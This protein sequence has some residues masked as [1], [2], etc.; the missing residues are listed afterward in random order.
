MAHNVKSTMGTGRK[1]RTLTRFA[2]FASLLALVACSSVLGIKDLHEGPAPGGAGNGSG[3]DNGNGGNLSGGGAN[4]MAGGSAGK[5]QS[6]GSTG[7]AGSGASGGGMTTGGT[8]AT[9]ATGGD[10]AIAGAGG[11]APVGSSVHGHVID[12]WGH[13][14]ANVPVEIGGTLVTTDELGAFVI[15][16][17]PAEYDASLFVEFPDNYDG[18]HFGW[19]FQGLT[20]RDPTLQVYS[21]LK[22]QS[23]NLDITPTNTTATL[24]GTRTMTVAMG[25]LDGS[26]EFTEV[27]AGGYD[28]ISVAWR[29]LGT[30]QETAHSLIWNA[31]AGLPSGYYAYDSQLVA[32]DGLSSN[33]SVVTLD[34]SAKTIASGNI[35]GTVTSSGTE[36]RANGVFLQFTSNAIITLAQD[37][38]PASFSYLVPTIANSSVI[39]SA[40]EGSSSEGD[41]YY[42]A[43][44]VVHKDTLAAGTSGITA[45][46]PK[47]ATLLTETPAS[48]K[49]KV[50][51]N[52]VFGFQGGAGSAGLYVIAFSQSDNSA[53]RSDGLFVVTTKK[54]FKMPKVVND[55]FALDPGASYYWRVETHGSVATTDAAAGPTGFLDEFSGDFYALVPSGPRRGD[56]SYTISDYSDLITMAP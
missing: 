22:F 14:L 38:G 8:G 4:A 11:E 56:G 9:G 17:V 45:V 21:G 18:G 50:D 13:K 51:S 55:S 41:A 47:V 29:G 6:G 28:G 25:G 20:R 37:S 16:D 44:A 46:I 26:D 42:G 39:F 19:V 30:T 23:G 31:T 24:T 12:Y 34:M 36:T 32:L 7:I 33:H 54:S 1:P 48:S 43:Y 15:D 40:S 49:T 27:S 3:G 2:P 10:I 52:T 35:G 53:L 5:G